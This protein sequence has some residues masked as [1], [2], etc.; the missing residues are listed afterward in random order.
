MIQNGCSPYR[1]CP[2][3]NSE[4]R[5]ARTSRSHHSQF[6]DSA[7][8]ESADPPP[9]KR[10]KP[11][12]LQ[13]LL[14]TKFKDTSSSSCS[15]TAATHDEIIS[16]ENSRYKVE[17]P[18]ELT[19]NILRWWKARKDTYPNLSG[20]ARRYLGIVATSVPSERL[21]SVAGNTVSAKHAA[22]DP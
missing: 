13:K 18:A 6:I 3:E 11:H 1:R 12:P 20:I 14:G 8:V 7:E 4:G 21:F 10:K 15:S 16:S 9:T 17:K 2:G 5:N 19:E 22:L